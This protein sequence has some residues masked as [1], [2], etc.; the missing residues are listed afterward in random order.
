M[1]DVGQME[2]TP[3]IVAAAGLPQETERPKNDSVSNRPPLEK[4]FARLFNPGLYVAAGIEEGRAPSFSSPAARN[5]WR[6]DAADGGSAISKNRSSGVTAKFD[7]PMR[8][9]CNRSPKSLS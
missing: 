7:A 5:D 1:S 2:S 4:P 8:L 9:R 3:E 6:D